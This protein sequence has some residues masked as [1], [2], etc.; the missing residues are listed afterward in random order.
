MYIPKE[1]KDGG[2]TGDADTRRRPV[3]RSPI[4]DHQRRDAIPR[5]KINVCLV[6][7]LSLVLIVISDRENRRFKF[8]EAT[9]RH[10]YISLHNIMV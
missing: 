6:H 10:S 3:E 2:R 5:H 1:R 7:V 9:Y 8:V 4:L